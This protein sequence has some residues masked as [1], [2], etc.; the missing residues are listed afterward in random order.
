MNRLW[1]LAFVFGVSVLF[2]LVVSIQKNQGREHPLV[3][4]EAP[5]KTLQHPEFEKE[6]GGEKKEEKVIVF[7]A[8]WCA[9][10][11]GV[12]QD[13]RYLNSPTWLVL[14]HDTAQITETQKQAAEK[15]F[16]DKDLTI[17]PSWGIRG[18]PELFV[19]GGDG[20]VL[21]HKAGRLKARDLLEI[22]E[23]LKEAHDAA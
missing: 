20:V 4:K 22:K 3:G 11:A 15:I 1:T 17:A 21:Y 18:V 10:C 2:Y 13:L 6:P 19:V 5:M 9:H 8:S 16:R 14:Y 12:L 7:L 23:R